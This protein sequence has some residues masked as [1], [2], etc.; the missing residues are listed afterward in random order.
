MV[1]DAGRMIAKNREHPT[2][3]DGVAAAFPEHAL[4]FLAQRLQPGDPRF[5]FL[6]LAVRDDVHFGTGPG[7]VVGKI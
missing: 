1:G 3:G 5:D 6:E 4:Q 2:V 7:G